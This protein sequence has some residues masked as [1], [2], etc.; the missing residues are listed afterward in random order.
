MQLNNYKLCNK[1]YVNCVS[2]IITFFRLDL[3]AK[4]QKL[5]RHIL[6]HSLDLW[7]I[8]RRRKKTYMHHALRI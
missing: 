5:E 6:Y 8:L 3:D 7:I 1:A 4:R 2:M